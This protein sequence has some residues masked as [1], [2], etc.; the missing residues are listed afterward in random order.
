MQ[1][2][3][4]SYN[5]HIIIIILID[6]FIINISI[7]IVIIGGFACVVITQVTPAIQ[8]VNN[9]L[10]EHLRELASKGEMVETKK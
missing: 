6:F 8:R 10:V 1:I 3:Y 9:S 2:W 5:S 7:T 4:F